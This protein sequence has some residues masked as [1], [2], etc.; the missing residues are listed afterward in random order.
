MSKN[1]NGPNS[2][3]NWKILCFL[4]LVAETLLPEPEKAP[5]GGL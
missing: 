3:F 2:E 4:Q 5:A 1:L